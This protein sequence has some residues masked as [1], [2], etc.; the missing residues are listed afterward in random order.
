MFVLGC[1]HFSCTSSAASR[2]V[3][4]VIGDERSGITPPNSPVVTREKSLHPLSVCLP[5]PDSPLIDTYLTTYRL[6]GGG[7][8]N[9]QRTFN[10]IQNTPQSAYRHGS[11]TPSYLKSS[12][13]SR[14]L[15]SSGSSN[16]SGS[17]N[18]ELDESASSSHEAWQR[19]QQHNQRYHN[20]KRRKGKPCKPKATALPLGRRSQKTARSDMDDYNI[21]YSGS[22]IACYQSKAVEC[23]PFVCVSGHTYLQE[24]V[25]ARTLPLETDHGANTHAYSSVVH[26][27]CVCSVSQPRPLPS[28]KASQELLSKSNLH[29]LTESYLSVLESIIKALDVHLQEYHPSP[30][31]RG[32]CCT[33]HWCCASSDNEGESPSNI[34][35]PQSNTREPPFANP[36]PM[37]PRHRSMHREEKLFKKSYAE[38]DAL[39]LHGFTQQQF[40]KTGGGDNLSLKGPG[41]NGSSATVTTV[42]GTPISFPT[43]SS[44]FFSSGDNLASKGMGRKVSNTVDTAVRDNSTPS[45][46]NH[47]HSIFGPFRSSDTECFTLGLSRYPVT[48]KDPKP[49]YNLSKVCTNTINAR[50]FA[51]LRSSPCVRYTRAW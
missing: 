8:S 40:R 50:I 15:S 7:D 35:G 4:Q 12:S 49:F 6:G 42:D 2:W 31:L 47:R 18:E 46:T 3:A 13:T 28:A 43:K 48:I 16:F 41:K 25:C 19:G 21:D 23:Y 27:D 5:Q 34:E 11:G 26:K 17:S 10:S 30:S 32:G 22:S 29:A 24:S 39:E 20:I 38:T 36:T 44:G 51:N 37:S 33:H 9:F 14:P 45:P 1:S